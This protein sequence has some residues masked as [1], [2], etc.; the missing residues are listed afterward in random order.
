MSDGQRVTR[1]REVA[2]MGEV[3]RDARWRGRTS[4]QQLVGA[5]LADATALVGI[6]P[7]G[8]VRVMARN[9]TAQRELLAR[10]AHLVASWNA[11][12]GGPARVKARKIVCWLRP[13][14]VTRPVAETV[15]PERALEPSAAHRGAATLGAA[16]VRNPRLKAALIDARA[17]SLARAERIAAGKAGDERRNEG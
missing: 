16:S 11:M 12:A 3:L 5:T 6:D 13:D 1:R 2:T 4:W 14:L 9:E 17:R 7:E 8:T 15:R 10:E